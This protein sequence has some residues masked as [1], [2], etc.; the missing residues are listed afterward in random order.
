MELLAL[1][2]GLVN[3]PELL[4]VHTVPA[5]GQFVLLLPVIVS[6]V[7]HAPPESAANALF[8]RVVQP[9]LAVA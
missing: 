6:L 9:A 3:P 4:Q 1:Q 8:G 2:P 7:L 5:F